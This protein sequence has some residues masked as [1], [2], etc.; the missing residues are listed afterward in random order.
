FPLYLPEQLPDGQAD[1]V[2]ANILAGPL[3]ELA[4]QIG[5]R[6]KPGG[7]LALSGILVAQ[8]EEV[9]AAYADKFAPDPTAETDGCG[10]ITRIL[11]PRPTLALVPATC[12]LPFG[13]T[14][15]YGSRA[16]SV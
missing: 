7:L 12:L 10:R 15:A 6:V 4:G 8:A 5:E 11:R 1:V 13:N 2:V 3:V 16:H 14:Q 9:R